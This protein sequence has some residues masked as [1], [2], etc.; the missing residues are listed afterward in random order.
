MGKWGLVANSRICNE[1]GGSGRGSTLRLVFCWPVEILVF[2]VE[3]LRT[4]LI[5]AAAEKA[6][7]HVEQ[8][9]PPADFQDHLRGIRDR[10]GRQPFQTRHRFSPSQIGS[11][12]GKQ[13][14]VPF[15][16]L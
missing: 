4:N 9:A 8:L 12:G 3:Q 16:T 13:H 14:E 5:E 11:L 2:H 1:I 6:M 10:D 7:F 15:Y